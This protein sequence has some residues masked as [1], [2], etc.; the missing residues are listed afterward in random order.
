MNVVDQKGETALEVALRSRQPQLARTLVEHRAD[1]SAKDNRGLSL[2]H[3][4]IVKGDSYSAE[5]IVEQLEKPTGPCSPKLSEIVADNG[6]EGCEGCSALHL[7]ATSRGTDM[8]AVVSRLLRAGVDPNH[9]NRKGLTVLQTCVLEENLPMID[10]LINEAKGL[11]L[12]RRTREGETALGLALRLEGEPGPIAKRLLE[13]EAEP[14]PTYPNSN[15][16]LTLKKKKTIE[17][18]WA[19]KPYFFCLLR[20]FSTNITTCTGR[21]MYKKIEFRYLFTE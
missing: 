4:S 13:A 17:L 6:P 19:S 21:K 11:D 18:F 12:E 2:L 15:G 5:F 3:S 16:T 14:N 1:L 10:L 8:L 20:R 9:Q 7:L